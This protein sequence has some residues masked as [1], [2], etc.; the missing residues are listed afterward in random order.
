MSDDTGFHELVA[1]M[2]RLR[3]AAGCPWDREQTHES[4][5]PYLLEEAYEVLEAIDAR[6]DERICSELGDVLLQVVFH[7]QIAGEHGRFTVADV[8]RAITSKL[9]TR[10]PHVFDQAAADSSE[11]VLANWERI[12]RQ[13]RGDAADHSVLDGLPR[14]LPALLRAQRVQSRAARVGFDWQEISGP[15]AKVEEEFS[16]LRR[17]WESGRQGQTAE[18]LGD[19]LFA[20]VNTARFLQVDPEEA[21]R[22]A[23]DKF[24][25]RFRALERTFRQRGQDL[26]QATLA[27]MDEVWEQ[28]K[29]TE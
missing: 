22:R 2:R 4:L 15:L 14:A 17:E 21:L 5:K 27:E 12:K 28:V 6:D 11:A 13:E 26:T 1:V 29:A 3:S 16:E 7:A 20:L 25:R 10:H 19:L 8:C 23:V 18:E 9:I 24:E